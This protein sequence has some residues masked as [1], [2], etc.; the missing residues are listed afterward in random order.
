MFQSLCGG[1]KVAESVEDFGPKKQ[2]GTGIILSDVSQKLAELTES[3][4]Q[5]HSELEFRVGG[6]GSHAP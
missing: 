2:N 1:R 6:M 4:P 5:N 3:G